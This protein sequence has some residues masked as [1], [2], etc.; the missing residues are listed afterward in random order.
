LFGLLVLSTVVTRLYGEG[1]WR[2][3][4]TPRD[5]FLLVC[6]CLLVFYLLLPWSMGPGGWLNDRFA[7]LLSLLLLAWFEEAPRTGWRIAFATIATLVA[8]ASA[9]AISVA[10]N[11]YA[12]GL[13][14]YT[15]AAPVIQKGKVFLPLSFNSNGDSNRIGI[16]VN[17]ANYLA[18]DK[19]GINLGN[20][21][22]QFDFF[23]VRFKN[24]FV[25]P[26]KHKE[27]V[28]TVY[29]HPERI[30]LCGYVSHIDYLE[31]WGKPTGITADAIR[32]CY[33]P[34]FEQGQQRIYVP[35]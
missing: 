14:E 13:A 3:R 12:S 16:Y 8:L 35:R 28:Q 18:M 22:V 20:Y 21:E 17:A 4:F 34:V 6:I 30:D 2:M 5:L 25:P 23:P 24:N 26:I 10:F 19:G 27:W 7:L 9:G 31:T 32:Q 33:A 11:H 1:K 15:A 29:W